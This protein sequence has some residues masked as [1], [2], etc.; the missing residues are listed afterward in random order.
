M[1]K[2][3]ASRSSQMKFFLFSY[4]ELSEN[5]YILYDVLLALLTDYA[6]LIK[7]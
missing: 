1:F 4:E 6:I 5:V 3:T 2:T 7:Y